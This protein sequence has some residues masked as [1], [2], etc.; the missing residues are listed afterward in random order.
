MTHSD[1]TISVRTEKKLKDKVGRILEELGLNHSI[2]INIYYYQILANRGIPFDLK[3][4]NQI[5]VK[6]LE[7]SRRK[8]NT[9]KFNNTDELFV[10]LGI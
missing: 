7:D 6:A 5:T 4:P 8:K 3:I 10:D 2:A 1:A 9:K